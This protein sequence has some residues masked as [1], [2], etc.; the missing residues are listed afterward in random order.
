VLEYIG[1]VWADAGAGAKKDAFAKRLPSF[2]RAFFNERL[3]RDLRL[4]FAL[5]PNPIDPA[6][7]LSSARIKLSIS[8]NC[9]VLLIEFTGSCPRRHECFHHGSQSAS[10]RMPDLDSLESETT[11]LPLLRTYLLS[12]CEIS[13]ARFRFEACFSLVTATDVDASGLSHH[14]SHME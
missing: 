9:A 1:A 4:S 13:A 5:N 3:N 7:K 8:T 2:D 10:K 11:P 6:L 14:Q 12:N